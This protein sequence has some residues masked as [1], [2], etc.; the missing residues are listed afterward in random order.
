M[1][2]TKSI[3]AVSSVP[4]QGF[5]ISLEGTSL[6]LTILVSAFAIIG[7]GIKLIS[8]FNAITGEIR[9]LKEE[10]SAH[11]NSE[12]HEKLM[13]RVKLLEK[14]FIAL[15]K[16]F[17]IHVQDYVNYKDAN[18]LALN[19]TDEKIKH[20][21]NKTEKLLEERKTDIKDLQLFLQKQQN[22]KIRE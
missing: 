1:N 16:R 10:L 20:T 12:G 18:L 3:I 13:Q 11:A 22:F 7:T 17:D 9:D 15:D 5:I 6:F 21:W 4:Q 19:T 8:K 14:D 2:T